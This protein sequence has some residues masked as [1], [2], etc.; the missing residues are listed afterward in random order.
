MI[1]GIYYH[2]PGVARAFRCAYPFRFVCDIGFRVTTV[3]RV[4][5]ANLILL[6]GGSTERHESNAQ[7]SEVEYHAND[8]VEPAFKLVLERH[9]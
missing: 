9:D 3:W 6:S 5:D 2:A 8:H 4:I 7:G 1:S